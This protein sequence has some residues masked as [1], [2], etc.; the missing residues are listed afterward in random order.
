MVRRLLIRDD[1]VEPLRFLIEGEVNRRFN[2]VRTQLLVQ[3]LPPS[4][5]TDTDPMSHFIAPETDLFEY[6]LGDFR[7]S[8]MVGITIRNQVNVQDKAIRLSIRR[9]D[10][11]T[12]NVICSVFQKVA[13]SNAR[14]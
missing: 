13:Q 1:E 12:E 5:G 8:D 4:A 14:F 3:M 10:Q 2:A 11:L 7:E 6:A 9:N